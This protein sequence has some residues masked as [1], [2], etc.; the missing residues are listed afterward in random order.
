M[1]INCPY[2]GDRSLDEF[3]YHGDAKSLIATFTPISGTSPSFTVQ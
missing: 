3:V 1:R 2:C